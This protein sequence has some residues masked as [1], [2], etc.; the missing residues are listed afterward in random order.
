MSSAWKV[1]EK[2]IAELFGVKRVCR[3]RDFGQS[4][5]DTTEHPIFSI[6]IKHRKTIPAAL[7]KYCGTTMTK[8]NK[9]VADAILQ[10]NG[11]YPGKIPIAVIHEKNKNILKSYVCLYNSDAI[12]L[13]LIKNAAAGIFVIDLKSFL[14]YLHN[15]PR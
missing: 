9:F 12:Y 6:E 13:G 5:P 4:L 15:S 11:Y 1:I 8:V 7:V 10:A 14:E 3:G 2:K